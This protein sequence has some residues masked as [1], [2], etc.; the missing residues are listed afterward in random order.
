M[1]SSPTL[2]SLLQGSSGLASPAKLSG[3][4]EVDIY[5]PASVVSTF[6]VA[7]AQADRLEGSDAS[8]GSGTTPYTFM[9]TRQ[10]DTASSATV[11]WSVTSPIAN[12]EDFFP[13]AALPSGSVSFAPGEGARAVI[14]AVRQDASAEADEPFT[15]SLDSVTSGHGIGTASATGVIRNDDLPAVISIS[16]LD[17]DRAEGLAGTTTAFTFSL[18]RSGNLSVAAAV[19]ILVTSE[20]L[21]E[22]DFD[23]SIRPSVRVATFEAGQTSQTFTLDLRGDSTYE[24]HETFTVHIAPAPGYEQSIVMSSASAQGMVRNDDLAPRSVPAGQGKSASF[25]FD[26]VFYLW[27]SPELASTL[28]LASAYQDYVSS[29]AAAGRLPVS[30]FDASYYSNRWPDL[31][32][33][34]LDDAAL[35]AHYNLYGVWEGRSGGPKFDHFDGHRYLEE[36]PDVAAYVDAYVADFLGSRTNGAI[37]H[38]VIYGAN[39]QRVAHDT[40][41]QAIDLGYLI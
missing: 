16:A 10:G 26:P 11:N 37:A 4:F 38:F 20:Q 25:L 13:F 32:P 27:S 30:W 18:T 5:G 35:F 9:I 2:T 31:T 23:S 29:G 7:A 21:D 28:T 34:Q 22:M 36:N 3:G 33:L 39:E 1:A 17:A 15:L 19:S 8:A 14:V 40:G 6:S 41:G 24:P 12:A